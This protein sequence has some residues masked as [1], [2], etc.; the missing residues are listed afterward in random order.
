M[1]YLCNTTRPLKPKLI[2]VLSWRQ[3]VKA[4]KVR[5]VLP[6]VESLRH[7]LETG[8]SY[9]GRGSDTNLEV[10]ECTH[11]SDYQGEYLEEASEA[12]T[13]P[14]R[15]QTKR[16]SSVEWICYAYSDRVLIYFQDRSRLGHIRMRLTTDT[17]RGE[18]GEIARRSMVTWKCMKF[19]G[20]AVR[21]VG[22]GGGQWGAEFNRFF[23]RF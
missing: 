23:P 4:G 7:R 11:E 22:M 19:L 18:R 13:Q 1:T 15:S 20:D 5:V 8:P 3:P 17:V 9:A 12:V 10:L 6:D 16:A 14:L 21:N 2:E